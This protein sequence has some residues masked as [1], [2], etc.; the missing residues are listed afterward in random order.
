MCEGSV[1]G[2]VWGRGGGSVVR[3]VKDATQGLN[4]YPVMDSIFYP[5]NNVY[6]TL[7]KNSVK[8]GLSVCLSEKL[9]PIA[10][11]DLHKEYTR[12]SVSL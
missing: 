10:S 12:G 6:T 11:I 3:E 9:T 1:F 8:V 4:V 5:V 2:C 7:I